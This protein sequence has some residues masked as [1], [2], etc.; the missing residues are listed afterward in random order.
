MSESENVIRLYYK[1]VTA[2]VVGPDHG[3]T[4]D[5]LNE[6]REQIRQIVPDIE[7]ERSRGE[8]RY[9]DLP[10]DEE[11]LRRVQAACDA[12]RQGCETL[13][14]CGIGG[15]ALGNIAL[16]T[17]LNPYTY[18]LLPPAKRG[19]PRL[20]VMDNVDPMQFGALLD[21]IEDDLDS[22][23]FNVISK[24]GETAETA[25]QFLIVRDML[26][27]RLGPSGPK[28]KILVT[29]DAAK[30]TMRQIVDA[31]GYESLSVPDGVGGR[32]SV[33]SAVGLF[34]AGMC[35]IDVAGLL[36]GAAAMDERVKVP[37]LD[38]N[39]AA[40]IAAI[41]TQMYHRNKRLHVMMPYSYHLKDLADW[42]RQ[43][44]AESLGKQKSK[45][46]MGVFVGPT[47]INALGATDQHSQVQLY[48]EGPNDKVFTL[49]A[50]ERFD[51]Q[52][53]IPAA[54]AVVDDMSYLGEQEM[55]TLLN[56]ERIATEQALITSKRPTLSIR[57]P[58][59]TAETVGQFIYLY[60][61]ATTI[62]GRLLGINAYDQPAVELGKQYTFA[63]MGR[64]G[65][66]DTAKEL[67]AKLGD[68]GKYL[69]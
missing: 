37:T 23:L 22:T 46:K 7:E 40:L 1:N 44:W 5:E 2:D 28:D 9:R 62:A 41:H 32:F 39:P 15:S 64:T 10:Y 53:S 3:L 19:G 29:T 25:A 59:I 26:K 30:G 56:N 6:A 20:F 14:V 67:R 54:D 18:N 51:R 55:G 66:E 35:G 48:R 31:E 57:F 43:L 13:V 36:K 33:L 61:A 52:V 17:A 69:V 11:M 63:L 49:L 8:H 68:V 65:F 34:S 50:V 21:L 58:S 4:E 27:Q 42:Y 24:S 60:E 12:R 45:F 38:E 47:P 16:Q